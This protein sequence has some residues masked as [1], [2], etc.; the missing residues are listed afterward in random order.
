MNHKNAKEFY[1]EAAE[2]NFAPA[3]CALGALYELGMGVDQDDAMAM[4]WYAKAAA[5]GHEGAQ[6]QIAEVLK[7]R[8]KSKDP[9]EKK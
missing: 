2:Q 9:Q 5:Q 6:A 8:R 4:R 7:K 1:E 3:Q